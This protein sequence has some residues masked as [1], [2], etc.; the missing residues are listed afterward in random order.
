MVVERGGGGGGGGGASSSSRSV[1][2]S[3]PAYT[4]LYSVLPV[5]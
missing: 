5:Q 4:A 2:M 3:T 1:S